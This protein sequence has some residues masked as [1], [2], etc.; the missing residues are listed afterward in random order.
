MTRSLSSS[1]LPS[2]HPPTSP[3]PQIFIRTFE[4]WD[5]MRRVVGC[6]Q[7]IGVEGFHWRWSWD[8]TGLPG[9]P[10]AW[11]HSRVIIYSVR[12]TPCLFAIWESWL[13]KRSYWMTNCIWCMPASCIRLWFSASTCI[14]ACASNVKT[15]PLWFFKCVIP[16]SGNLT[17]GPSGASLRFFSSVLWGIY[18]S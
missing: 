18:C 17:S 15:L 9:S 3:L 16:K 10:L 11:G 7:E 12:L 1:T 13:Y 2:H 14:E 4:S 8:Q 5:Y 6:V